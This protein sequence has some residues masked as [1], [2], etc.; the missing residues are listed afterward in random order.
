M[1]PLPFLSSIRDLSYANMTQI[2]MGNPMVVDDTFTAPGYQLINQYAFSVGNGKALIVY[3]GLTH[4]KLF[5]YFINITDLYNIVKRHFGFNF[6]ETSI[7]SKMGVFARVF[8]EKDKF[9]VL[10]DSFRDLEG[11][12]IRVKRFNPGFFDSEDE[13]TMALIGF[14]HGHARDLYKDVY[15]SLDLSISDKTKVS[16]VLSA[17]SSIF[18]ER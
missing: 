15:G 10:S 12:K 3:Q 14:V 5:D 4:D 11:E 1:R 13:L 7:S 9:A 8:S 6:N 17:I 16:E 18:P 2:N